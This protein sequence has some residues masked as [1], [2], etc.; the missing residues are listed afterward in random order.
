MTATSNSELVDLNP[1]DNYFDRAAAHVTDGSGLN[2]NGVDTHSSNPRGTMWRS[3]H[4]F[5]DPLTTPTIQFDL[6]GTYNLASLKVWNYNEASA[7][8]NGHGIAT[9]DIQVSS[10]NG[11]SW[12]TAATGVSLTRAPGDGSTVGKDYIPFGDVLS[13]NASNITN[14]PD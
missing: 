8:E 12:T 5:D 9:M 7:Y 11:S 13:L 2:I 6:G 14:V 1:G 3:I 10:D 4:D